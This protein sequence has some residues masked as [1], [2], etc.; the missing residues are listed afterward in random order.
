[1]CAFIFVY[2]PVISLTSSIIPTAQLLFR[3]SSISLFIPDVLPVVDVFLVP[4]FEF[5]TSDRYTSKF[6]KMSD[7]K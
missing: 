2:N 1:V 6:Q 5:S 4:Y 7:M 3:M